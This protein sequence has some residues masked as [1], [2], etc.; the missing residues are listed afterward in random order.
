MAQRDKKHHLVSFFLFHIISQL[1]LLYY[2]TYYFS[3]YLF[4]NNILLFFVLAFNL[5][6]KQEIDERSVQAVVTHGSQIGD[7]T[8]DDWDRILAKQQ[9]VFARYINWGESEGEEH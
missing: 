1:L 9:I 6:L 4:V 2:F 8:E 5:F 3:F 7:L